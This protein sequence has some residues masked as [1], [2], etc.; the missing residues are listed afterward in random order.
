MRFAEQ[1]S[2]GEVPFEVVSQDPPRRQVVRVIDDDQ[3]FGGTWTWELAPNGSGT[4]VTLTEDG[5]VKS[6]IVITHDLA[7][8]YQLADTILVMYAGKLAEKAP[9]ETIVHSPRHPYTQ[10]LLSSLPEVGTRYE[11]TRLKGIAGRPPSLV[12]PPTGC[13]FRDRCPLASAVCAEEPPFSEVSPGHSVA[14]WKA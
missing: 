7:V 2:M 13:R 12:T 8:L 5:F 4:R 10:L 11:K 3:P 9:A 14:C 1:S 6:A